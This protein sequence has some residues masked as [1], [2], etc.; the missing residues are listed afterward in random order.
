M[1]ERINKRS[2]GSAYETAAAGWLEKHGYR[3]LARNFRCRTGEID[4]IARENNT[5]A[6]IEVKYRKNDRTGTPFE[7]VD[8]RKQLR[9]CRA[10]D[11]YRLVTGAGAD[12]VCRFDVVGI[13]GNRIRLIRNA[14]PYRGR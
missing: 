7:A 5:L 11:Y 6:F 4:L 3:I 13:C 12:T 14:F 10:A 9:I 8:L 2:V 1:Q